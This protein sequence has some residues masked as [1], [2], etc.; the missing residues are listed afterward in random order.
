MGAD[1][2][3]GA[4]AA[5]CLVIEDFRPGA[6][7]GDVLRTAALAAAGVELKRR[8]TVYRRALAIAG[9]WVQSP[10]GEAEEAF[11]LAATEIRVPFSVGAAVKLQ[12]A[13]AVA[14]ALI[15]HVRG[16]ADLPFAATHADA[17]VEELA[18]GTGGDLTAIAAA[19]DPRVN[20]A[21]GDFIDGSGRVKNGE[22]VDVFLVR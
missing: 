2:G 15:L 17:F 21:L 13:H 5:A 14:R 18:V 3:R 11:T 4:L 8:A 10:R 12:R 19:P 1:N 7:D 9:V 22:I 6:N 20:D 16:R